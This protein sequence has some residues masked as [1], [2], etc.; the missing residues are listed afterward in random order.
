MDG[1]ITKHELQDIDTRCWFATLNHNRLIGVKENSTT[2]YKTYNLTYMYPTNFDGRMGDKIFN[3]ST[4]S[5]TDSYTSGATTDYRNKDY[6]DF[7][8]GSTEQKF[9]S[10]IDRFKG[11]RGTVTTSGDYNTGGTFGHNGRRSGARG[12]TEQSSDN[13]SYET[14]NGSVTYTKYFGKKIR[15]FYGYDK[16]VDKV[17]VPDMISGSQNHSNGFQ[18]TFPLYD[19][20]FYFYFGLNQ[21][22]TA[23]DKF[24]EMFFSKCPVEET[25]PFIVDVTFTAATECNS[26]SGKMNIN[27]QGANMPY[28]IELVN[29]GETVA[30]RDGINVYDSEFTGLTNGVYTINITDAYGVGMSE[31]VEMQYSKISLI[32]DTVGISG[33]TPGMIRIS[34]YTLYESGLLF[35]VRTINGSGGIYTFDNY[36]NVKMEISPYNAI[37]SISHNRIY[38]SSPTTFNIQVY[39]TCNG[40]KSGNIAY[41]T[42]DIGN[43][44]DYTPPPPDEGNSEN[45]NENNGEST[46]NEPG[47]TSTPT[48]NGDE[49][50]GD[51]PTNPPS[52]ENN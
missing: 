39:E 45:N 9:I 26:T 24:Y 15:H 43:E 47:N 29:N 4:S 2:G 14:R 25:S 3:N 41:Y 1:L 5:I 23:I 33:E 31:E 30:V 42:I 16:D 51:G 40:E 36:S 38:V 32:Y 35:V 27:V 21:G 52:N 49:L 44:P 12:V 11:K 34:G 19:N 20:S 48:I 50:S 17:P 28:S 10:T 6:L 18:Y 46:G 13:T 37:S 22:S 7:R 8:F